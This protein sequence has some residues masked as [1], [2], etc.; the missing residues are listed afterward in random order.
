MVFQAKK[1]THT[2]TFTSVN[3]YLEIC[4]QDWSAHESYAG[5]IVEFK[6]VKKEMLNMWSVNNVAGGDSLESAK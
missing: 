6:D 5:K 3:S 2:K 4:F 1:G